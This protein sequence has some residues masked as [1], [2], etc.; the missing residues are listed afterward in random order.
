MKKII[1]SLIISVFLPINI[2]AYSLN[3]IPGGESIG[4]KI[5]TDGLII[6]GFYKV[7][8]EY[9][10]KRTFK[11]G[12]RIIKINGINVN[13]SDELSGIIN[14]NLEN[15]YVDVEYIRNNKVLNGKLYIEK[16]NDL[17]KTG[18]YIKDNIIGIGTLTYIDPVTKIYGS[19]GHEV[20]GYDDTRK[21]EIK[22]GDLLTSNVTTIKKSKDG[23]VGSKNARISYDEKIGTITENTTSGIFGKYTEKLPNKETLQV[24]DFK[25]IK[26]DEA[27]ILTVLENNE[28]E[29]FKIKIVEKY[30]KQKNT[31]KAFSFEIIDEKLINKTGGIVQG[32]SG[33][34]IIQNDKIIGAVTNV[35]IS[36]VTLGY[37]ISIITMLEEGEN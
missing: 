18:L 35:V 16:E 11:I 28:V 15:N 32:M 30:N 27:Y 33:S 21:V 3:I 10:G 20:R 12:D 24:A 2:L 19:L 31:Q 9:I 23:Y 22:D 6:N 29:K 36:D 13:N 1:Y 14:D 37:G 8:N 17:Y 26:E 4:I 25:E 7:N 5:N 34:P